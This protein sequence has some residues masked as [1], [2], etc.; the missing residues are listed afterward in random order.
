[1]SN[2]PK[3]YWTM[4]LDEVLNDNN[5]KYFTIAKKKPNSLYV[6]EPR[7]RILQQYSLGP[8]FKNITLTQREAECVGYVLKGLKYKAIATKMGLSRRTVETYLANI[9]N[10]VNC[11]SKAKLISLIVQSDFL[12]NYHNN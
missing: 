11:H 1:M 9:R 3:T 12:Q 7:R 5:T 10:K 6:K 8:N 4:V 2:Q